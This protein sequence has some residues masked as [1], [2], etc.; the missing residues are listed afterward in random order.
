MFT[1]SLPPAGATTLFLQRADPHLGLPSGAAQHGHG[2]FVNT[3]NVPVKRRSGSG[4]WGGWASTSFFVGS[5]DGCCG[6]VRDAGGAHR[7]QHTHK[8]AFNCTG[9]RDLLSVECL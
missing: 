4:A 6:G 5:N 1:P 3:A 9:E 2:L 7:R 8:T